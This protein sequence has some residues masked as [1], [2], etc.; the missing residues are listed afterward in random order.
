MIF[1]TPPLVNTAG[2]TVGRGGFLDVNHKALSNRNNGIP[3]EHLINDH[4]S[5]D[6]IKI[7]LGDFTESLYTWLRIMSLYGYKME[8]GSEEGELKEVT[9]DSE[10]IEGV[11]EEVVDLMDGEDELC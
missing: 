5:A 2:M 9:D 10:A 11:A 4:L 7:T 8:L 1:V 6:N 3:T